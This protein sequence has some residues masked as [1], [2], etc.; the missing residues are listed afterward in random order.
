MTRQQELTQQ[1]KD[2]VAENLGRWSIGCASLA[3]LT[4]AQISAAIG[5][6]RTL[7]GALDR[8]FR[9]VMDL[10]NERLTAWWDAHPEGERRAGVLFSYDTVNQ[11]IKE[12]SA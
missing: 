2:H 9:V 4:D 11:W 6:A 12:Q 7:D 1:V 5:R 10:H 3:D 8:V